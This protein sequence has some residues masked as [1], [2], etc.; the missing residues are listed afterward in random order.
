MTNLMRLGAS[1]RGRVRTGV[2]HCEAEAPWDQ[3]GLC[4]RL[5]LP[6]PPHAP[7]L[8]AFHRGNTTMAD[9]GEELFNP[10]EV[11]SHVAFKLV[12]AVL[13]L[14]GEQEAAAVA[15]AGK[16]EAWD[17]ERKPE[18]EDKPPPPPPPPR[19]APQWNGPP[20]RAIPA[21]GFGGGGG[22]APPAM[23]GRG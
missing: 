11:E 20:P 19:R 16:G 15:L 21:G 1:A 10:A 3:G 7:V 13:R 2:V 23:L 14:S 9:V 8:R 17:K 18:E 6:R 5:G 12:E 22:A 4:G